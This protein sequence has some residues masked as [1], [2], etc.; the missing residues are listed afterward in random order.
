M[1]SVRVR[2]NAA[3]TAAV[4]L[5][6][7]ACRQETTRQS[8]D[9]V[10]FG[11]SPPTAVVPPVAALT[12]WD[13]RLGSVFA[14]PAPGGSSALLVFP[15]FTDASS[16]DTVRFDMQ[17]SIGGSLQLLRGGRRVA[18]ARIVEMAHDPVDGC[19][20]WPTV[21]LASDTGGTLPAEWSLGIDP[22]VTVAQMDSLAGLSSKDST[23]LT[24][25]LARVASAL[26]GDTA[27]EFR[28]RPFVVRQAAQFRMTGVSLVVAEVTRSVSQ[29]AMPLLEH[30]FVIA[31]VDSTERSGLRVEYYE[32]RMGIEDLTETTET[33]AIVQSP[34]GV[35]QLLVARD[36]GEG[37]RYSLIE[38]VTGGEWRIRWTSAYAGC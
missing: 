14:I 8:K 37:V 22:G 28:G 35:I 34:S 17:S 11:D 6:V 29:E 18:T 36:L 21:Q 15:A 24:V 31:R 32:R 3:A 1:Y 20:T 23:V 2:A 7:M 10:T 30:L 19:P 13:E 4:T 38:R 16:L 26:P 12:G 5:L 27:S 9:T 33:L 25:A